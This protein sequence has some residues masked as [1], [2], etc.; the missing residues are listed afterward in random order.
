MDASVWFSGIEAGWRGRRID[1][2]QHLRG[3]AEA[4]ALCSTDGSL[5]VDT[6]TDTAIIV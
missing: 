5:D 3:A 4:S 1:L 6:K 2:G